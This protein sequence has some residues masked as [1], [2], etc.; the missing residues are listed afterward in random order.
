MKW[1]AWSMKGN[2]VCA[3]KELIFVTMPNII[4]GTISS[5][6]KSSSLQLPVSFSFLL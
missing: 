1:K 3:E 5:D 6:L 4:N 2:V